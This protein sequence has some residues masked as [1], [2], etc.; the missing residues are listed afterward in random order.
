MPSW[1]ANT[2]HSRVLVQL[3]RR[4]LARA[5]RRRELVRI[6]H[7]A[8]LLPLVDTAPEIHSRT[9]P[10]ALSLLFTRRA[11]ALQM[12][13]QIAF[14]GGKVDGDD[15]NREATAMREAEE[16]VGLPRDAVQCLGMLDDVHTWD[17]KV[18]VTPVVGYCGDYELLPLAA[19]SSE[20]SR[21][22]T[23]PL[24][25]LQDDQRWASK[26]LEWQGSSYT[27]PH[28]EVAH[29][30]GELPGEAEQ[31]WGLSAFAVMKLL[32]ELPGGCPLKLT[33]WERDGECI[34]SSSL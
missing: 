21:I 22:F 31:L 30:S 15:E 23:V 25:H 3:E 9:D 6:R 11:A 14:P 16:E 27:C 5:S 28:F 32:E 2:V 7:A 12:G 19:T 1:L 10:G 33:R 8:I 4:L 13:G 17:D 29:Y 26:V 24:E 34:L 18:S 20:V